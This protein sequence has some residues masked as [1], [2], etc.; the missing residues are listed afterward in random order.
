MKPSRPASWSAF[1]ASCAS[2]K[3]AFAAA[4]SASAIPPPTADSIMLVKSRRRVM[5][6][7]SRV[8]DNPGVGGR[9]S[10]AGL[11]DP[12]PDSRPPTPGSSIDSHGQPIERR[13]DPPGQLRLEVGVEALVRQVR[14]VGAVG[15]DALGDADRLGYAQV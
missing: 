13:R 3:G 7:Y 1:T 11:E 14:E 2:R 6:R 5:V 9:E 8:G 12:A 4:Q 15:A 10:G